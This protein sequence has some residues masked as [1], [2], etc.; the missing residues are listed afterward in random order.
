L[1]TER[2]EGDRGGERTG[3]NRREKERERADE[4]L[5]G[6]KGEKPREEILAVRREFGEQFLEGGIAK[7]RQRGEDR[8]WE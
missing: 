8:R 5:G 1:Q 6:V 2:R 4:A 3:E 7:K